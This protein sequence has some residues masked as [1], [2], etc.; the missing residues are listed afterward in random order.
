[1]S[2]A[3]DTEGVS[4]MT[5]TAVATLVAQAHGLNLAELTAPTRDPEIRRARHEAWRR[6]RTPGLAGG[7]R[8][9]GFAEIGA[10]FGTTR[11]AVASAVPDWQGPNSAP[12]PRRSQVRVIPDAIA[13]KYEGAFDTLFAQ[14]FA[15]GGFG[16]LYKLIEEARTKLAKREQRT[17]TSEGWIV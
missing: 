4:P 15:D 8:R 16:A 13:H 1:M 3:H 11:D 6:L 7:G 17:I 2:A 12:P 9:Y 5:M 10:F 14:A